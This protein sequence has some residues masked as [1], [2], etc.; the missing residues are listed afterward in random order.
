MQKKAYILI[1]DDNVSLCQSMALI[2]KRKGYDVTYVND[3]P[4]AIGKVQEKPFDMIFMDIKMPGM[5]GVEAFK[6]INELRPEAPV[7]MMTA[8]AV[9]DM[10]QEA[11]KHGASGIM[12][13]PLDLPKVFALLERTAQTTRPVSV[14]LVDHAEEA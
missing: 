4:Q 8:Y 6:R 10:V 12:Y 14:L 11:L 13:K 7:V 9:E 2:L 1:V 5:D 3:G